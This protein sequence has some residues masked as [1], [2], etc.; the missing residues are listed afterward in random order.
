MSSERAS[1]ALIQLA[2]RK[3]EIKLVTYPTVMGE[4]AARRAGFTPAVVGEIREGKT[5]SKDTI[6]AAKEMLERE[7]ILI[8]FAGGDG[9]A[10]DIY[11]AIDSKVP[12]LGIPSG[13]KIHS[14]VYA[15]TPRE[16]GMLALRYLESDSMELLDAEVMDIDEDAFR[17]NRVSAHL[18]GYMKVPKEPTLL[19]GSKEAIPG[20]EEITLQGLAED[21]VEGMD[22]DYIYILGPGSTT[23]PIAERLGIEKT[24]LGVDIIYNGELLASD[25]NE[26]TILKTI[27]G[28]RAK[29][30]V[31][32]IGGQ[33]FIFGRGNQQ[34]SAQV[35]K[36]VG[37]EN[38]I[39]IATPGKLA[40]LRGRTLRVDTGEPMVDEML[41]GYYKVVTSYG[42]RSVYKVS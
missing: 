24:L 41:K 37:K 39:V 32:I 9:T 27:N 21:I 20:S 17:E 34:I 35:I 28:A 3:D 14:G 25:A 10:R 33:G 22:R 18:Y 15:A 38:I 42:R 13:V 31:T 11:N 29:I 5:T 2:S 26:A 4:N 23:R 36:Q 7:V 6:N 12:V 19:Q 40:T 8:L 30:I 1:E 16:A